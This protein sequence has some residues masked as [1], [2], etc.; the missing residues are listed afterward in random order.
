MIKSAKVSTAA[1]REFGR[2]ISSIGDYSP[3]LA[4]CE[5][6]FESCIEYISELTAKYTSS[7]S[8][9]QKSR[10]SVAEKRDSFKAELSVKL[11]ELSDMREELRSLEDDLEDTP[12]TITVTDDDG[13]DYEEDNPDYEELEDDIEELE[14]RI[15]EL[16]DDIEILRRRIEHADSVIDEMDHLESSIDESVEAFGGIKDEC[17]KWID[18]IETIIRKSVHNSE[19]AKTKLKRIEE[20][21]GE[22]LRIKMNC[23]RLTQ[24]MGNQYNSSK[25]SAGN[26]SSNIESTGG[27]R[28]YSEEEIKKHGIKWT[29]DGHILIYDGKSFGGSYNTYET[30]LGGTMDPSNPILGFYEGERGESKYIPSDRTVEG[31]VVID[32]LKQYNIDGIEYR[33]AEPDFE[34]CSE[35]V[36]TIDSMTQFRENYSDDSGIPQL[37]NFM[38]AD[39]A[40]AK[41][42]NEQKKDGRSDWDGRDVLRYRKSRGLTWHEKSDAKTMVMMKS[43]INLFFKHRGGCSE[44]RVRDEGNDIVSKDGVFD[45]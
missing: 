44:C 34:V 28:R 1:V 19:E 4:K 20:I 38:Q 24:Q 14:E 39:I 12:E 18:E 43:E 40:C 33:N 26:S 22:Y 35:A 17:H 5:S 42:W 37:G 21:I 8:E 15:D 41:K 16:E 45:D 10:V 30:R 23:D 3:R 6:W 32:I 25:I 9:L 36:V 13:E 31:I 29:Q 2:A 7:K 27:A 11:D